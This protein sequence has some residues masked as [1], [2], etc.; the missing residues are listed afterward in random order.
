MTPPEPINKKRWR[1]MTPRRIE[2][3]EEVGFNK[4]KVSKNVLGLLAVYVVL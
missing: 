2:A 1:K 4:G 3:S